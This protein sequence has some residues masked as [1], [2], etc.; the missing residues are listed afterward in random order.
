MAVATLEPT[1]LATADCDTFMKPEF[2][3]GHLTSSLDLGGFLCTGVA[4]P[5]STIQEFSCFS[6]FGV[7]ASGSRNQSDLVASLT[8][9]FSFTT[10]VRNILI[11]LTLSL[12]MESLFAVT[13]FDKRARSQEECRSCG[14]FRPTVSVEV[15]N[16][17]QR[18]VVG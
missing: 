15:R 7:S 14:D 12:K 11:G 18:R 9:R 3:S 13:G 2:S 6:L 17:V 10:L 4:Q 16:N 1:H 5:P 8:G